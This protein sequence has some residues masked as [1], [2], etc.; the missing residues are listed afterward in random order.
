MVNC[1]ECEY[2]GCCEQTLKACRSHSGGKKKFCYIVKWGNGFV[3]GFDESFTQLWNGSEQSL[4]DDMVF[5][6]IDEI[7]IITPQEL[8]SKRGYHKPSLY[9][10]LEN[11]VNCRPYD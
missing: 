2:K 1:N 3:G 10:Y 11:G 5:Y 4:V 8:D 6:N 9:D 7:E